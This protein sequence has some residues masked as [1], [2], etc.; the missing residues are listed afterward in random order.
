MP[1]P[2]NNA[3]MTDAGAKLLTRAQA[4]EIKIEFT[5]IAV[6]NGNYTAEEKTLEALQKQTALKSLKNSY[7][8]SGVEVYSDH[9][10]KITAII[11]NQDLVT[12]ETLVNHGYYIN[13]MGLF[14]KVKD[15]ADS[16]EILYNITTTVGDNG[17][18]MPPYNGYNSAQIIQEF[19]VTVSNSAEV[20]LN[21]NNSAVA[22]AEDVQRI[23]GQIDFLL[24]LVTSY[25]YEID[26]EMI[27]TGLICSMDKELFIIPSETGYVDSEMLM[28]TNQ[29]KPSVPSGGGVTDNSYILLPATQQ[30]LGGVKIGQG[31]DVDT[32]GTISTNVDTSVEKAADL[33]E[34]RMEEFSQ[35]EILGLFQSV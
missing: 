15:G 14:A 21:T 2:F 27:T 9:S 23:R 8:L 22:L 35:E 33:V 7:A 31:I 10:V 20:T 1:Q 32:D 18:F 16:T 11:T 17:D 19:Y 12:K 34:A 30:R 6:G 26:N 28:L 25:G 4:G 29:Y 3:V 13:E 24:Q 5:R